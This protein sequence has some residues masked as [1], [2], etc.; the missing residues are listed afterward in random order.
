LKET[1]I[2]SINPALKYCHSLAGGSPVATK[3]CRF[4]GHDGHSEFKYW[5]YY[6]LAQTIETSKAT[7]NCEGNF[8]AIL[9][10]LP[11]PAVSRVI[12]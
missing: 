9:K 3:D 10:S 11:M 4:R 2:V 8:A 6:F 1:I 7:P 12:S 5:V